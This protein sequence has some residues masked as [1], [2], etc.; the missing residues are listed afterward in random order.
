[1]KSGFGIATLASLILCAGL[2]YLL[3]PTDDG[4]VSGKDSL[5]LYCAAGISKPVQEI[6]NA[7]E[8]E[9]GVSIQVQFAGSGQLLSSIKTGGGDVYLAAAKTY[10]FDAREQGLVR[11][12]IPL[13]RQHPVL[14]V[15]KGNPKQITNI[16]DLIQGKAS[17]VQA[18]ADRTAIGRVARK[19]L[20]P[21]VWQQLVKQATVERATVNEVANDIKTGV[22]DAGIIWSATAEQYP[23]LEIVEVPQLASSPNQI[24]VGI[25]SSSEQPRRA[26]HFLRYMGARDRGLLE[27]AKFGYQVVPG[28]KWA[29]KP[30]ITFFAGGLNRLAVETAV[31]AFVKREGVNVITK[32]NGCGVLVGEMKVGTHPDLYFSCDTTFMEKV[33]HLF[34]DSTD[35]SSTRM[36]IA[37]QKGN[38]RGI[39]SLQDLTQPDLQL[40]LCD[41][42]KSALGS[43]SAALLSELQILKA[44]K[45][46]QVYSSATAA[47]LVSALVVGKIDAAIVYQANVVKQMHALDSVEI[48]DERA[49]AVQPIAIGRDSEQP[50]LSARLMEAILSPKN[51]EA[52]DEFGFKWLVAP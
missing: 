50:Q 33:Q 43:L 27:F 15:L 28:D 31:E 47:E 19:L 39:K 22:S 20:T 18:D 41:P 16:D 24:T 11:E 12:I 29:E 10:L 7:Y 49:L 46:N 26:L 9:Y 23:D 2:V 6:L 14:A 5:V 35:V 42:D 45:A 32:Y 4:N 38:P 40:G 34:H 3:Q 36:V 37:V 13:A 8:Q 25:L 51:K 30:E 44:A 48:A 17:S 52:F 21:D 1:M